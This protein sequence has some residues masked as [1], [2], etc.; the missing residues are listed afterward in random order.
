[1]GGF[2]S[3][4]VR[5]TTSNTDVVPPAC[6]HSAVVIGPQALVRRHLSIFTGVIAQ[7]G[8]RVPIC[9]S[10]AALAGRL[11]AV[12]TGL[13]PLSSCQV[14]V[15]EGFARIRASSHYDPAPLTDIPNTMDLRGTSSGSATSVLDI[16]RAG[17]PSQPRPP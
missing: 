17:I 10:L 9:V 1:V 13:V 11:H 8:R 6:G 3:I 4:S 14:S 7:A 2:A 12:P 5:G 15:S 16:P